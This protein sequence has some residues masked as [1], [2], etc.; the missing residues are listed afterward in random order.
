[1]KKPSAAMVAFA[2]SFDL[3]K[4]RNRN[5]HHTKETDPTGIPRP[6]RL[7]RYSHHQQAIEV[8]R[9]HRESCLHS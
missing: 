3:P 1:M 2:T 5:K 6:I 7:E 9:M 8:Q 4:V